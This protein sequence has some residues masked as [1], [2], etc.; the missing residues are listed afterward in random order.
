MDISRLIIIITS[1]VVLFSNTS[2]AQISE[3]V[4]HFER[5]TN[6][7]KRFKD[8]DTQKYI[9]DDKKYR[10]EKFDLYFNDS[11][12]LFVPVETVA[13]NLEWTTYKNSSLLN[14]STQERTSILNVWGENIFV[15]DS[16]KQREWKFTDKHRVI[17]NYE[18]RQA[19]WKAND[20]VRI[21]AWFSVEVIPSVGPETFTGLPGAILG[22]ALEDGRTTYF[23]TGIEAK[24]VDIPKLSQK[25]AKGKFVTEAQLRKRVEED[26]GKRP[27]FRA[28]IEELFIW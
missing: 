17:A 9:G 6:L 28:F 15:K 22:L 26:F 5:K 23:A 14:R 4:I 19:V 16:I 8:K 10:V 11:I 3:G 13:D 2:N 24:K 20:S 25:F 21:Y 7:Y 12:S 1:W 18:C 27:E